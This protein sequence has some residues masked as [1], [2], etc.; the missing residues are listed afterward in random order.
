MQSICYADH[1]HTLVFYFMEYPFTDWTCAS[2]QPST[3]PSSLLPAT[4]TTPTSCFTTTSE[5]I[6][7]ITFILSLYPYLFSSSSIIS[8]SYSSHHI[9]SLSL[10]I[11]T[12]KSVSNSTSTQPYTPTFS[13]FL[14]YI[15][16]S[17]C[18]SNFAFTS[19]YSSTLTPTFP[20]RSTSKTSTCSL[21]L[22]YL[23]PQILSSTSPSNL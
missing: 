21:L 22:S 6:S 19:I 9:V 4:T 18:T 3:S 23:I 13:T 5:C 17:A 11:S 2:Q 20:L 16:T 1:L 7:T 15:S 8:A 12:Y 10:S 14:L